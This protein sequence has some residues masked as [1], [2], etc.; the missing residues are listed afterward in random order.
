LTLPP[1]IAPRNRSPAS[2]A[3]EDTIWINVVSASGWDP[4]PDP[5]PEA[6]GERE[7]TMVRMY[8]AFGWVDRRVVT[9][10]VQI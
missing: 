8:L 1:S 6:T 10:V 7:D 9:A 4:D 5:D 3:G 2:E